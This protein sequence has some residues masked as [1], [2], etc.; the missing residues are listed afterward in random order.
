MH[1]SSTNLF[2]QAHKK[3]ILFYL[4]IKKVRLALCQNRPLCQRQST[5]NYHNQPGRVILTLATRW[6]RHSTLRQRNCDKII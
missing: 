2:P 6:Y 1:F 5:H 4:H 3:S